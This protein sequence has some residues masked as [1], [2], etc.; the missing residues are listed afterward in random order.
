MRVT[1]TE[2]EIQNAVLELLAAEHVFAI[3]LNTGAG[4]AKG[5]LIQ[6]HSGGAGVADIIAFPRGPKIRG[7]IGIDFEPLVLWIEV[8]SATGRQS[9]LQRTFEE[10]VKEHGMYYLLARSVDDVIAWLAAHR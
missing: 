7:G 4:W 6:H 1:P 8:K 10:H 5:R 2:H 9:A 3:R